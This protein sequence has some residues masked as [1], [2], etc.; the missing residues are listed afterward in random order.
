M[1][2]PSAQVFEVFIIV[3]QSVT[4]AGKCSLDDD[5]PSLNGAWPSELALDFELNTRATQHQFAGAYLL[6]TPHV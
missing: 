1:G 6:L 5:D 2:D 4:Q 3:S